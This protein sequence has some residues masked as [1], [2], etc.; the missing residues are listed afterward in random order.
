MFLLF[1]YYCPFFNILYF[2]TIVSTFL[3]HFMQ[4]P[5]ISNKKSLI[6]TFCK[7]EAYYFAVPLHLDGLTQQSL[8]LFY[9]N[10]VIGYK[11]I[12]ILFSPVQFRNALHFYSF[13]SGVSPDYTHHTHNAPFSLSDALKITLSI[14]TFY[15][16]YFS[17][18]SIRHTAFAAMPNSAP[19]NPSPSSVVAL[20][21]TLSLSIFNVFAIFCSIACI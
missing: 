14:N 12:K 9:Y 4:P 6:F 13:C 18:F 15:Y 17:I 21:F 19:V 20:T 16:F 1:L 8:S 10:V 2:Y 7:D 5:N 3:Y 11:L